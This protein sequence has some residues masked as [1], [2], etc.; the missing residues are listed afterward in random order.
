MVRKVGLEPTRSFEPR[1]L[2]PVR[3]PVPPLAHIVL[4]QHLIYTPPNIIACEGIM[5]SPTGAQG[6]SRTF[7]HW[8][9]R[10][11]ALPICILVHIS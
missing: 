9:L 4:S 3:L 10:P 2:S 6:K 11:A 7:K 8:F 1:I 5:G